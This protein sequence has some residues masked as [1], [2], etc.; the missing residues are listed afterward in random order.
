[1][2]IY[3]IEMV[4]NRMKEVISIQI[5]VLNSIEDLFRRE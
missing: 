3:K 2:V 4:L 1:M 5:I